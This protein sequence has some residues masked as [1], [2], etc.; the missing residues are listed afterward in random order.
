M[1]RTI[2]VQR[3]QHELAQAVQNK[4]HRYTCYH[5]NALPMTTSWDLEENEWTV[6]LSQCLPK[7]L[8]KN[9]NLNFS[10]RDGHIFK[11][12]QAMYS[13]TNFASMYLF[14]GAPDIIF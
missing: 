11:D 3:Y 9:T 7:Y 4:S 14:Q 13:E 5:T 1:D 10:F 6:R 2:E 8:P 12:Y